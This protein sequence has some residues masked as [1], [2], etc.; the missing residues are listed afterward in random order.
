M[1]TLMKRERELNMW[2]RVFKAFPQLIILRALTEQAMTGY[3]IIRHCH[4]KF[5]ILPNSNMVY[6]QLGKM[7]AKKWI[8][9]V[10]AKDGKTYGLTPKGQRIASN[11]NALT[12]EIH[13]AVKT[14][15]EN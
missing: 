10:E 15:M 3:R 7:E 4:K 12:R 14:M 5:G 13:D 11:M 8:E 9:Q 6:T 1:V 2:E